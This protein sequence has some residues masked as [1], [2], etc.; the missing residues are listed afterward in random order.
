[1]TSIS[2]GM[3]LSMVVHLLIRCLDIVDRASTKSN[4]L[5]AHSVLLKQAQAFCTNETAK[6]NQMMNVIFVHKLRF[7]LKVSADILAFNLPLSQFSSRTMSATVVLLLRV[8]FD[9]KWGCFL[10]GAEQRWN[11]EQ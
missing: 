2:L 7:A 11:R 10:C 5:A 3:R 4:G 8:V 6:W 9:V 1:M